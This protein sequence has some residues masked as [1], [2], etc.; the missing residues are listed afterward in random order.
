MINDHDHDHDRDRGA[1][2]TITPRSKT[3]R[4]DRHDQNDQITIKTIS[5]ITFHSTNSFK[6]Y[7]IFFLLKNVLQRICGLECDRVVRFDRFDRDRL[8]SLLDTHLI[9]I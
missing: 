7:T 9:V 3:D 2:K 1:I 4:F 8:T 5:T 6:N